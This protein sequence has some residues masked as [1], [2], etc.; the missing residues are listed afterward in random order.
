M[1]SKGFTKMIYNI[2]NDLE[3][4]YRFQPISKHI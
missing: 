1:L 4:M 3:N 2:N